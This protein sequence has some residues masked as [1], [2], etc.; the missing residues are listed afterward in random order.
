MFSDYLLNKAPAYEVKGGVHDILKDSN[1]QTYIVSKEDAEKAKSIFESIEGI[2][3][4]SP[5]AVALAS[6]VQA[7]KNG[8]INPDDCTVLNISGGGIERMKS[9]MEISQITSWKIV[10]KNDDVKSIIRELL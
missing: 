8:E 7:L 2:D 10:S 9:D 3:I 6:L 4:M 5:G 1:G